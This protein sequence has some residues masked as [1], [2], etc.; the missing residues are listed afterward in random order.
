MCT[1]DSALQ[2]ECVSV[3]QRRDDEGAYMI[4][5]GSLQ[6]IVTIYLRPTWGTR[7]AFRQSH[8]I[9]TPRQRCA[10]WSCA[11]E[12]QSP[13]DALRKAISSLTTHY[14]KAVCEGFAPTE[15]WLVPGGK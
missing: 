2:D 11:P 4:R 13:G 14:Q 7:T 10:D 5:I 15:D 9:K 3:V 12:A 1:V 8:A 6:T